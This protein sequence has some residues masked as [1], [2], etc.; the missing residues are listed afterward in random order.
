M[1]TPHYDEHSSSPA[2][3]PYTSSSDPSLPP[4]SRV[5]ALA[6][7]QQVRSLEPWSINL[8][9]YSP[10]SPQRVEAGPL[11]GFEVCSSPESSM[12]IDE[13]VEEEHHADLQGQRTME[14]ALDKEE[15]KTDSPFPQ[16]VSTRIS[17]P[18]ITSAHPFNSTTPLGGPSPSGYPAYAPSP[19]ADSPYSAI[20]CSTRATPAP[21]IHAP[22]PAVVLAPL[23]G[24]TGSTQLRFAPYEQ[25]TKARFLVRPDKIPIMDVTHAYGRAYIVLLKPGEQVQAINTSPFE[26][27]FYILRAGKAGLRVKIHTNKIRAKM[28]QYCIVPTQN[29]YRV[30]NKEGR[31]TARVQFLLS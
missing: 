14:L 23:S 4:I 20:S 3:T 12:E 9:P 7:Q 6:P 17:P 22:R 24:H 1:S 5:S 8:S 2:F 21:V 27:L 28:G 25:D 26:L 10:P 15:L 13:E 31:A 18:S 11:S 16:S 29:E 19:L 30:R